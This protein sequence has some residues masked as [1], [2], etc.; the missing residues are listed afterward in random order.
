LKNA[1]S[2]P[3]LLALAKRESLPAGDTGFFSRSG[4]PGDKSVP[5]EVSR[6]V[7]L[8]ASGSTSQP[9]STPRGVYLTRVVERRPTDFSGLDNER[10]E[11]ERQLLEQKRTR[12]WEA[13]GASLKAEA[14]IQIAG[15]TTAVQ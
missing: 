8:L 7:F 10:A 13:Y 15:Q 14:K 5:P 2:A 11:I 1:E 9:V 4:Q 12:I 3:D 6:A